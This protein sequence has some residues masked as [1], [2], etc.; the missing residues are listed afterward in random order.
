MS[1]LGSLGLGFLGSGFRN[2]ITPTITWSP[3][4]SGSTST[5]GDYTILTVT[6][7]STITV[8]GTFVGAVDFMLV[9]KGGS[10]G[11]QNYGGG[12]GGGGLVYATGKTLTETIGSYPVVVGSNVTFNGFTALQGGPTGATGG[13]DPTGSITA[14]RPGGSGGGSGRA[15]NWLGP[16]SIG[17][18]GLQPAQPQ[19]APS[20]QYGNPGF[21]PAASPSC[22]SGGGGAGS[23]GPQN[24]QQNIGGSGQAISITGSSITYGAGGPA[25]PRCPNVAPVSGLAVPNTSGRGGG[26]AIPGSLII[27]Y[28]TQ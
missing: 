11:P 20:T 8:V 25:P 24:T 14:G 9:G 1:L 10:S 2:Y 16:L 28:P 6:S 13:P 18:V 23:G 26:G 15:G 5:D 27:R 17:G 12:G 4:P 19:S 22:T 3:A 7:P 21:G